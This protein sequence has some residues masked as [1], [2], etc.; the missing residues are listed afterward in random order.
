MKTMGLLISH[1]NNEKRRAILPEHVK[2]LKHPEEMYFET[3]YGH[4][5]GVTDQEYIDCGCHVVPREEAMKCDIITDVKLGD[6]DYL[7]QLENG[8]TLFGWAHAAQGTAFTDKCLEKDFTVIAWEEV[9]EKGRYIFY[10]NREVAGEAAIL[11]AFCYYGRMPYECRVAIIGNGQTAK[12]ALRILNG[13]GA[14]VDVYGRKLEKLFHEMKFNYDV[15]VNCVMWDITRKDHLISKEELKLLKPH[16]M[17]ID[18]SCDPH[19]GIETSHPTTIS[20]P[21]YTVDNVLHYAVDNTPAMFPLTVTK[22]LSEGNARIFDSVIEDNLTP[23]LM[24]AL[25]IEKGH[26]RSQAIWNFRQERGLLCK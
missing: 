3:G 13:L 6:A 8:K 24:D 5:V 18:V 15:I 2:L 12:G 21:V 1:K 4:T 11:Q 22:V 25:V 20:D 10:R 16:A 23:A 9:F 17:I 7:D 19:L 26:I 14:T